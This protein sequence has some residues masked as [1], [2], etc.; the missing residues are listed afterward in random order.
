[1]I[2]N[3]F[4]MNTYRIILHFSFRQWFINPIFADYNIM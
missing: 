1:M 4:N 2:V 3:Q